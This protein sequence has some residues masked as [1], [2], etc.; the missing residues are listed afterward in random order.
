MQAEISGRQGQVDRK[1]QVGRMKGRK[2]D[3]YIKVD[4][5]MQTQVGTDRSVG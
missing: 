2:S 1:T 5:G 3:I 4:K